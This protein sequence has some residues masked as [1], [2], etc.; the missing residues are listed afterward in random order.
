MSKSKSET[1]R[2]VESMTA[3]YRR[4]DSADSYGRNVTA[5]FLAL[6]AKWDRL[7]AALAAG[8]FEELDG[9]ARLAARYA[10]LERRHVLK[11]VFA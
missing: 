5:T 10:R 6:H 11:E 9:D 2:L 8:G 4:L 1:R 3:M 7:Q